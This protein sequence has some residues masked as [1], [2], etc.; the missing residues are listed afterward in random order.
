[1]NLK[2]RI[3]AKK[4]IKLEFPAIG[5]ISYIISQFC[6]QIGTIVRVFFLL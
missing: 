5:I 3:I 2:N 1:M 4:W 6:Q